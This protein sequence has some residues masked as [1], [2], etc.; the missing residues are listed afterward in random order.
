MSWQSA[1]KNGLASHSLQFLYIEY[2]FISIL[3]NWKCEKQIPV[4][5][6]L[7][8]KTTVDPMAMLYFWPSVKNPGVSLSSSM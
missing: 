1:L 8:G 4:S 7:H 5:L 6:I 2:T 3:E